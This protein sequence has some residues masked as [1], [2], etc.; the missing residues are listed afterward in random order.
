MERPDAWGAFHSLFFFIGIPSAILVAF[1][2]RGIS[3]KSEKNGLY[4]ALDIGA[5]WLE[6]SLKNQ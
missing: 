4:N 3:K 2:L 6:R 1:F 5:I